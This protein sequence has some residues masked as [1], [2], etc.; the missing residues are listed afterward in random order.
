VLHILVYEMVNLKNLKKRNSREEGLY[1]SR[2]VIKI[3]LKHLQVGKLKLEQRVAFIVSRVKELKIK[4]RRS[5][6]TLS[7]VVIYTTVINFKVLHTLE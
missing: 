7:V 4:K 6:L 2:A 5:L 1:L 3:Y